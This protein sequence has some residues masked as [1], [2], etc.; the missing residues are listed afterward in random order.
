MPCPGWWLAQVST[1]GIACELYVYVRS[2][3]LGSKGNSGRSCE[4]ECWEEFDGKTSGAVEAAIG[5][6]GGG[7]ENGCGRGFDGDG[8]DAFNADID[9]GSGW[10]AV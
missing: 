5:P 1:E 4:N 8:S 9:H 2:A 3:P 6:G 7:C 10:L